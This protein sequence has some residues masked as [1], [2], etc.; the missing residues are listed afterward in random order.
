MHIDQQQE[1][2]DELLCE[3]D[4][5]KA[6]ADAAT[7]LLEEALACISDNL[8]AL[9]YVDEGSWYEHTGELVLKEEQWNAIAESRDQL[10]AFLAK[11][12]GQP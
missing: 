4:H 7:A 11:T 8:P 9:N 2:A 5:W 6:R 3:I 12:E 10:R 1:A